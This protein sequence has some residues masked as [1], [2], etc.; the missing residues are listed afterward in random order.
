MSQDRKDTIDTLVNSGDYKRTDIDGVIKDQEGVSYYVDTKGEL[1]NTNICQL[2]LQTA[3]GHFVRAPFKYD[4]LDAS[5]PV[6]AAI[7]YNISVNSELTDSQTEYF[8]TGKEPKALGLDDTKSIA[9]SAAKKSDFYGENITY[10]S[11]DAIEV[12]ANKT[13]KE[14]EA[15]ATSPSGGIGWEFAGST[16][17]NSGEVT[18]DNYT[19]LQLNIHYPSLDF[20]P[21][22]LV[23]FTPDGTHVSPYLGASYHKPNW[24]ADAAFSEDFLAA[25]A[26]YKTL[27]GNVSFTGNDTP[28]PHFH[29]DATFE[30]PT[31]YSTLTSLNT[32]Y[33]HADMPNRSNYK[34]FSLDTEITSKNK[35]T[36]VSFTYQ[37]D[38]EG[39]T[40][41]LGGHI[42]RPFIEE[43]GIV[44][45]INASVNTQGELQKVLATFSRKLGEQGNISLEAGILPESFAPPL[46]TELPQNVDQANAGARLKLTFFR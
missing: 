36:G 3:D 19:R 45:G 21:G 18:Q 32:S 20:S 9:P 6:Y 39:N 17:T 46:V 4:I 16:G 7:V 29:S 15:K 28:V 23:T 2:V 5:R 26:H 11:M 30:I 40:F 14:S 8:D 38:S 10:Y 41:V 24:G 25:N 22:T 27:R 35:D 1:H 37:S 44:T 42:T 13:S 34:L 31:A 12:I 33:T 43:L